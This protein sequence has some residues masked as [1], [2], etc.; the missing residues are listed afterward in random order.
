MEAMRLAE[1]GST[2]A[3]AMFVFQGLLAGKGIKPLRLAPTPV[4]MLAQVGGTAWA[5][6]ASGDMR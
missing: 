5:E 6:S 3:E 1:L 2:L 4:E